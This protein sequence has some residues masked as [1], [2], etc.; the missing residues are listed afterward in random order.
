MWKVINARFK[1]LK[2][3]IFKVIA[4]K[5]QRYHECVKKSSKSI[6]SFEKLQIKLEE[7]KRKK[8]KI[9]EEKKKESSIPHVREE[10]SFEN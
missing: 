4:K 10:E 2:N 1:Y 8:E 9:A 3:V 5:L 7:E 6:N